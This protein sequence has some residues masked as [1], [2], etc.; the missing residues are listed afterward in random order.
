MYL[1]VYETIFNIFYT[2]SERS[3]TTRSQSIFSLRMKLIV[4]GHVVFVS[5]V[6][7]FHSKPLLWRVDTVWCDFNSMSLLVEI[8]ASRNTGEYTKKVFCFNITRKHKITIVRR[9]ALILSLSVKDFDRMNNT[10][11]GAIKTCFSYQ[12]VVVGFPWS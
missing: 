3:V 4:S 12:P 7:L 10:R 5:H 1:G 8:V 6:H 11:M 9:T 2:F